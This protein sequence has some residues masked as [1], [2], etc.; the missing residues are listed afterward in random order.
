MN[1]DVFDELIQTAERFKE[2]YKGKNVVFLTE[3]LFLSDYSIKASQT[4]V[5]KAVKSD[6]ARKKEYG[7]ATELDMVVVDKDTGSVDLVDFKTVRTKPGAE[8]FDSVYS[9]KKI[10]GYSKQQNAS[11]LLI[12]KNTGIKFNSMSLMPI[13]VYYPDY[14]KTTDVAKVNYN[15]TPLKKESVK[16]VFPE[17]YAKQFNNKEKE[18]SDTKTGDSQ[19]KSG[20]LSGSNVQKVTKSS[21]LG[22]LQ[23][24][25]KATNNSKL[26][27]EN[28][29]NKQSDGIKKATDNSDQVNENNC[30]K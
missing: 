23:R 1:Q 3:G 19:K 30:N 10:N 25:K 14:G 27:E 18:I 28:K 8:V 4:H 11:R 9:E 2:K 21:G 22:G 13:R 16:E 29:G 12:E 7:I 5:D 24:R 15:L 20:P 26:E 17:N 6:S